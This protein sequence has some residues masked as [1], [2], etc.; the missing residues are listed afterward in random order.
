MRII[1]SIIV[2]ILS[3]FTA[4]AQEE[5]IQDV[6]NKI[7]NVTSITYSTKQKMGGYMNF[8]VT[9]KTWKNHQYSRVDSDFGN[10]LDDRNSIEIKHP[11]TRYLFR[12]YNKTY[13][14]SN[15]FGWP[16]NPLEGFDNRIYLKENTYTVLGQEEID[17][18]ETTVLEIKNQLGKMDELGK[19]WIW[20]ETGFPL[21][22]LW[23][24]K[25][26]SGEDTSLNSTREI[27]Y[28]FHSFDEIPVSIF[29]VESYLNEYTYV[30][31]KNTGTVS[32]PTTT[33]KFTHP[34][35]PKK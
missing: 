34:D 17:G 5:S 31:P 15:N 16:Q 10:L 20:N 18:K 23:E 3:C 29:D 2:T 33:I 11:E 8:D 28:T 1:L 26:S 4:Q 13:S 19:V 30:E 22:E 25:L 14:T 32:S 24:S 35:S 6:L 9:A 12:P 27:T 7:K 21:K